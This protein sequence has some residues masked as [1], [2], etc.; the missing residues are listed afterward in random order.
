MVMF[1]INI[2]NQTI[3]CPTE[4]TIADAARSQMIKVPVACNGG[5]CGFCKVRV[6]EGQF[7]MDKYSKGALSDEELADGF[8]LTCKTHPL[9]DM[10]LELLA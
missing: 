9:S 6:I 3:L 8:V 4:K 5:G 2:N 1:R 7:E 10:Q